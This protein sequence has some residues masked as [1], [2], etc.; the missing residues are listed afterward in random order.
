MASCT[1][2]STAGS[3]SSLSPPPESPNLDPNN[4]IA[5]RA[6]GG[7]DGHSIIE[8]GDVVEKQPDANQ[9][10]G[11]ADQVEQ[12]TNN[13]NNNQDD[14]GENANQGV[15]TPEPVQ[16][17]DA[18]GFGKI[19]IA[20]YIDGEFDIYEYDA[21]KNQDEKQDEPE[22]DLK[23]DEAQDGQEILNELE[24]PKVSDDLKA[25]D[26]QE[27]LEDPVTPENGEI[28]EEVEAPEAIDDL[29]RADTPTPVGTAPE[30]NTDGAEVPEV[31]E[32]LSASEALNNALLDTPAV[33]GEPEVPAGSNIDG[34]DIPAQSQV[35]VNSEAPV[36]SEAASQIAGDAGEKPE[37]V[38]FKFKKF[39]PISAFE[40][41]LKNAENMSYE[42]LYHRTSL[43]SNVLQQ[44]Q[45]EYDDVGRKL[46]NYESRR[47]AEKQIIDEKKK[48]AEDKK[49]ADE[50]EALL[51]ED[52]TL[53]M[54]QEKYDAELKLRG[55]KWVAFVDKFEAIG[56][57][58]EVLDRLKK[59]HEVAFAAALLK[60]SRA[61]EKQE[62][63][64]AKVPLVRGDLPALSKKDFE[65]H[66]K[67]RRIIQDRV[68]FDE[69]KQADVY[70]QNYNSKMSGNQKLVDR[71]AVD[72]EDDQF[73]ESGR[74]KRRTAAQRAFYDT[75]QSETPPETEPENLPLK[76]SRTKRVLDDGIASPGRPPTYV[77]SR[78]GTPARVFPSGKRVG[79]PPGSKTKNPGGKVPQSKLNTVHVPSA[80]ESEAEGGG[81]QNN[82][83]ESR[84]QELEPA[85]EEQLQ[86]A[87]ESLV[88]QTVEAISPAG[89]PAKKK[90]AG[91]RPKKKIAVEEAVAGPSNA[92]VEEVSIAP[93]PKNKG[94][95][96][97]KHPIPAGGAKGRGGR[98]KKEPAAQQA[99][100]QV[101]EEEEVIQSTEHDNESLFPS[102]T[103]S[104][105]ST[106][107]SGGTDATFGARQTRRGG[108][109]AKSQAQGTSVTNLEDL[110]APGQSFSTNGR[111]K[112]K[113]AVT[114]SMPPPEPVES[115]ISEGEN[116]IVDTYRPDLEEVASEPPKKRKTVRTK[117]G[118]AVAQLIAPPQEFTSEHP[119][120]AS[121]TGRPKRKRAMALPESSIDPDDL[122]DYLSDDDGETP[123]P[124]KR[125]KARG[126][127]KG[128]SVMRDQTTDLDTGVEGDSSAPPSRKR[129]ARAVTKR[130]T[131][132][133]ETVDEESSGDNEVLQP[134][135]TR[136][137]RT[138][139]LIV[140]ESTG[141]EAGVGGIAERYNG[142]GSSA[143][144][145]KKRSQAADG[146]EIVAEGT[147]PKK[148]KAR[149]ISKGKGIS[150]GESVEPEAAAFKNEGVGFQN[151]GE[152]AGLA[153]G[154]HVEA[155]T[156]SAPPLKKRKTRTAKGKA[157]KIESTGEDELEDSEDYSGM[158][159]Q[160]AE[161]LRKKK[162]KSRKLAAATRQRWANGSMKGPMDKRKA[163]NAAKKAAKLAE[164]AA[165]AAE[166]API[167]ASGPVV[168]DGPAPVGNIAQVVQQEL[169]QGVARGAEEVKKAPVTKPK[170]PAFSIQ[171][172]PVALAPAP[173]PAPAPARASTRV[174]K[175]TSRSMGLDGAADDSDDYD[176]DERYPSAYH[177]FQ[178]L[179]SPKGVS[180]GK[181]ARKSYADYSEDEED[182]Y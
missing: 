54:L 93:K 121:N 1:R 158:D 136:K 65:P 116:I 178:A 57:E 18:N 63:I 88:A 99:P 31:A 72:L 101:V 129:A 39:T 37:K 141:I 61:V 130:N 162:R 29:Y 159:P 44:Y 143:P 139:T 25:I 124:S 80:S 14:G 170:I 113:R 32:V 76:R 145:P 91:G 21:V 144:A 157:T 9:G 126:G 89:G 106:S 97:R 52:R 146:V 153:V 102:T 168:A 140:A 47:A 147:V 150:L 138:N 13:E 117:K 51:A 122:G 175:P 161:I 35:T 53:L 85:Q 38:V 75:E 34:V 120:E 108:T 164:K 95:R 27:N 177:E 109:R 33:L 182:S 155:D 24:D 92:L 43:I 23:D 96:P 70:V 5:V 67:R 134:P 179:T 104:R 59:L 100:I 83:I 82:Q 103:T 142:E 10:N 78:D 181:R 26:D 56:G 114:E 22:T 3:D 46:N 135:K 176:A 166:P 66:F 15:A 50:K 48:A 81:T 128:K 169:A 148:R 7:D 152:N 49:K 98:F 60:R 131:I 6:P 8:F 151:G 87:A 42:E 123:P 79:R 154:G 132:K 149:A 172:G 180:L 163:T 20:P 171:T 41:F 12:V 16:E 71:N 84:A 62:A 125:R 55:D 110:D 4:T 45:D 133:Q 160:E 105:P 165:K 119:G 69:K 137:S 115:G 64:P 107:S 90:H 77:E 36:D 17:E 167:M 73:N 28:A 40:N 11:A 30:P 94:G 68:A 111:G 156:E 58:P 2:P 127:R 173:P 86:A 19:T 74:P 174:R 112:R 118:K